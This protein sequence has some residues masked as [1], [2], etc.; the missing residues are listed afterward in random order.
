M[1][2]Y[3]LPGGHEEITATIGELEKVGIIRAAHSPFNFPVWPIKKP[4]GTWRMTVDYQDLNEVIPPIH[5]TVPSVVDLMDQ[6]ANEL[7]IYHFV[8]NLANVFFSIDIAPESQDQFA[9]A[10]EG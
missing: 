7:G 10:W 5:A 6:L 4:D 1:I 8:D 9:F 2:Q 3:Q